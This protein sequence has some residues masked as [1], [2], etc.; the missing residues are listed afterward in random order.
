V[1]ITIK[2]RRIVSNSHDEK[3]SVL[4]LDFYLSDIKPQIN[5]MRVSFLYGIVIAVILKCV[6]AF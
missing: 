1:K 2:L 6:T 5:F 3:Y 4:L